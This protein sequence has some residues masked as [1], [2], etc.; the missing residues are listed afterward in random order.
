[1]SNNGFLR[2]RVWDLYCS[3][4]TK[5]WT[6]MQS[7]APPSLWLRTSGWEFLASKGHLVAFR[8]LE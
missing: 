8:A 5:L 1:M 4:P 6:T 3:Q 7:T 2:F